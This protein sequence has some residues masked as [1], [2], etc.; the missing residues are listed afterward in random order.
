MKVV[1]NETFHGIYC[2]GIML[3]P[4]TNCL[5][6]F[7]DETYEAKMYIDAGDLSV[8][9]SSK[10]D[11]S[12]KA[13]AVKEATSHETLDTLKKNFKDVDITAKKKQLE[14]FDKEIAEAKK[15]DEDDE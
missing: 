4:G 13:K 5:D 11:K 3:V 1:I 15:A 6:K 12:D 14:K 2:N 9:D 7:D 8:K 10:M